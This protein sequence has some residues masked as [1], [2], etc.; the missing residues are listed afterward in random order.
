[1]K[2]EAD[3]AGQRRAGAQLELVDDEPQQGV[4]EAAVDVRPKAARD[5]RDGAA[6]LE[7]FVDAILVDRAPGAERLRRSARCRSSPRPV[8]Q[9]AVGARLMQLD[10]VVLEDQRLGLVVDQHEL[11]VGDRGQSTRQMA[12]VGRGAEVRSQPPAEVLCLA[13]IKDRTSGVAHQVTTRPTRAA[14]RFEH[15]RRHT[16]TLAHGSEPRIL[17]PVSTDQD[18]DLPS[19]ITDE[20]ELLLSWLDFLRGAVLRKI[21]GLDEAQARWTPE[22]R[23]ISLLG[24]VNHLAHVEWRW[25]DGGMLGEKVSRSE[26]EFSP[27]AELTVVAAVAAYRAR[28]AATDAAVRAMRSLAEPCQR[29]A[30]TDLRWGRPCI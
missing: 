20:R 22:G 24:I 19:G 27:G 4:S 2:T 3:L 15:E 5:W 9:H 26:A 1:M 14:C 21:E 7:R 18:I 28:A 8:E 25:I 13:D 11:D 17:E 23:L 16:P 6:A 12:S 10:E 30:G 29:E